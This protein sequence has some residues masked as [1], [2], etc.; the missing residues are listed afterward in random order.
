MGTTN[1]KYLPKEKKNTWLKYDAAELEKVMEYNE[2][3]RK[4]IS[5][6]KTEREC[7]KESIRLA[8]LKGYRD[9]KAV[10]A[11]GESLKAGDKVYYNNMDKALVLFHVGNEPIETGMQILGAHIDSPRIDVK[12]NPLY[13]DTEMA[14]LDTHYYGGIKKYQWVTLPMAIHG[15]VVLLDGTVKE[16]VIGEAESDPVVGISDLLVHLSASQMEKK[17]NKV[18]E[19]EDLNVLIGSMPLEGEEKDAVKANI[20]RLLNEKYG[21]EEADFLSAEL[22]IVPAGTARDFGIDRSMITGYGHDDRVCA[23]TSLTAQLDV[24]ACEKT[25]V[26]LLVDKEEIGSI[27]A[28]GM[29]SRFFENAVAEVMNCLGDY[30][31]LK[32]RRAFANSKMLSSDVSAAFDPNY[33]SVHEKKNASYF[34]RGLNFSKFFGARGKSGAN[35]A[36]PEFIAEIR[37]VMEENNVSYQ[38][39][40]LGKVDEGGGGTISK[41]MAVYNMQV[42]DSG[43]PVLNMHSPWEIVSK[44]DVYEAQKGFFTFLTKL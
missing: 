22:E 10:I 26:C 25:C 28:T 29:E 8:M 40:E 6:C 32:L 38:T 35:D 4:F 19:G 42:I 16:I 12:Q 33:P 24:E 14:L 36:N 41:F 11:A 21:M 34:G 13:E 37:K 30:S 44:A 15:V 20:L 18:I 43:V 27:G 2:G 17:A 9:L 1:S 7:V 5:A 39:S 3:Y 23:Y 31:E